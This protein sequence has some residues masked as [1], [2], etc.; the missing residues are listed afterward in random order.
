MAVVALL[1]VLI[2]Y[3]ILDVY[4]EKKVVHTDYG[5]ELEAYIMLGIFLLTS[6]TLKNGMFALV[7]GLI[8]VVH[9]WITM[10]KEKRNNDAAKGL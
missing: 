1:G 5:I 9:L 6:L 7:Y 2:T 3:L 10:K 4:F 8:I